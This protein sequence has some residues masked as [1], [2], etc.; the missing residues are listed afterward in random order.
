MDDVSLSHTVVS[1]CVG[2]TDLSDPCFM[3]SLVLSDFR[4]KTTSIVRSLSFYLLFV[5]FSNFIY[6]SISC[7]LRFPFFYFLPSFITF[8]SLYPLKSIPPVPS[9]RLFY[10]KPAFVL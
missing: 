9:E 3:L 8:L 1:E 2:V 10:R 5:L 6:H 7:Y 4:G